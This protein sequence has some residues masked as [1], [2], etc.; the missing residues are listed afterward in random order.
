M[1]QYLSKV[2]LKAT[3]ARLQANKVFGPESKGGRDQDGPYKVRMFLSNSI[4]GEG[5]RCEENKSVAWYEDELA[6]MDNYV[7]FSTPLQEDG[8]K[9]YAILREKMKIINYEV[10]ENLLETIT[11]NL[12]IKPYFDLEMYVNEEDYD[13]PHQ[14]RAPLILF[15]KFIQTK[16]ATKYGIQLKSP[17][18]F[19]AT[20]A[21]RYD[22]KKQAFKLSFHLLIQNKIYFKTI[23]D[24]DRF[25]KH[26]IGDPFMNY[27]AGRIVSEE[28]AAFFEATTTNETCFVDPQVYHKGFQHLK[29]TF[30]SK[31]GKPNS[32]HYPEPDFP[33]VENGWDRLCGLYFG[34]GDRVCL[35]VS[36]LEIL[37]TSQRRSKSTGGVRPK[38]AGGDGETEPQNEPTV[39]PPD[40][41]VFIGK[42][43]QETK[44]IP[45]KDL[46][47]LSRYSRAKMYL[48][49]IPNGPK[50]SVNSIWLYIGW[51]CKRAGLSF[52]DWDEW[53]ALYIS[54]KGVPHTRN[55]SRSVKQWN[56]APGP[57][58]PLLLDDEGFPFPGYDIRH[59]RKVA[60]INCAARAS[61][62][63]ARLQAQHL[64]VRG[65]VKNI[66]YTPELM[67]GDYFSQ[68]L[69]GMEVRNETSDYLSSGADE[70]NLYVTQKHLI[71]DA[72]MGKGKTQA[73]KKMMKFEDENGDLLYKSVLFFSTR[74]S[75]AN[76]I[77]G[78]DF[79]DC[80][81]ENYKDIKPITVK[82]KETGGD[83]QKKEFDAERLVVS[84]E[85]ILCVVRKEYDLVILD[86]C[87]SIFKIFSSSTLTN[88]NSAYVKLRGFI[89]KSKRTIYADAF[90]F[91]R[92]LDFVRS[93]K[94]PENTILIRNQ[95][96]PRD[97]PPRTTHSVTSAAL[98]DAFHTQTLA[99]K[100]NFMC[101]GTKTFTD[102]I[103]TTFKNNSRLHPHPVLTQMF[104]PFF[105]AAD[106]PQGRLKC[107]THLLYYNKHMGDLEDKQTLHYIKE[108]WAEATAVMTTP[109]ITVGCSFA[110]ENVFH[111]TFVYFYPSCC[112][113]DLIQSHMRVRK[114][115]DNDVYYAIPDKIENLIHMRAPEVFDNLEHFLFF[116]GDQANRQHS[117][118]LKLEGEVEALLKEQGAGS[119]K[120]EALA[121][122][123]AIQRFKSVA[124]NSACPYE[125]KRILWFNTLEDALSVK[126]FP[127][128]VDIFLHD[129]LGYKNDGV[130]PVDPTADA[131]ADT[132]P[133]GLDF[134]RYS[135][136]NLRDISS[137][138]KDNL[139][140]KHYANEDS[141]LDKLL[142]KKYYFKHLFYLGNERLQNRLPNNVIIH[143]F[144][145]YIDV[146]GYEFIRNAKLEHKS[147]LTVVEKAFGENEEDDAVSLSALRPFAPIFLKTIQEL[148]VILGLP[149]S[150]QLFPKKT[151]IARADVE[152][153]LKTYFGTKNEEGEM[154]VNTLFKL[155]D[156][157]KKTR[158]KDNAFGDT[159]P[160]Q[161]WKNCLSVL[162][163][164]YAKWT[165]AG[166]RA[167]QIKPFVSDKSSGDKNKK[168][169]AFILYTPNADLTVE[170]LNEKG[171]LLLDE[172][173]K[174]L[175]FEIYLR[176][177][178]GSPYYEGKLNYELLKAITKFEEEYY[179]DQDQGYF[180]PDC[181][182]CNLPVVSF[183]GSAETCHCKIWASHYDSGEEEEFDFED[184]QP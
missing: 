92:T 164:L 77:T 50:V 15:M 86:E 157:T 129:K 47:D 140:R 109:K 17:D 122:K 171:E 112:V 85:S 44:K 131:G 124:M 22:D 36:T 106:R 64:T 52:E 117:E 24:H 12:P 184:E 150:F 149:N 28:D 54:D 38:A 141:N 72:R 181:V 71:Y 7:L 151:R 16:V 23:T 25:Y 30:Q 26:F 175:T 18:D 178:H 74:I 2:N 87:E 113:R 114:L 120:D 14:K 130:K 166:D 8:Y 136:F 115:I 172:K 39:P 153:K 42:T 45:D 148:N 98:S 110:E 70:K 118:A 146:A 81:L 159:T 21:H 40:Y 75:F 176:Y 49:L 97:R 84:L 99:G 105:Y 46:M 177:R 165:G 27:N 100:K 182:K 34:V 82:N 73:I 5:T 51:A 127:K 31:P 35:D 66:F 68:N 13:S 163:A 93:F 94:E 116:L 33:V 145:L 69:N 65:K 161:G 179:P 180:V 67:L 126:F 107:N 89:E 10:D 62:E 169:A 79:A 53:S 142:V 132:P 160:G 162:N 4:L 58:S 170:G 6:Y 57:N 167:N 61:A 91:N 119:E 137:E 108:T 143:F 88:P 144:N 78:Q 90:I 9:S 63:R 128:M 123:Q 168:N 155:I 76:F 138:E 59:L 111:S 156:P 43:L 183:S 135:Y 103:E 102:G 48:Y 11:P 37:K 96:P 152:E 104:Q 55:D 20:S 95:L 133:S 29:M 83:K 101:S 139:V 173:G 125:L 174:V 80:R 147:Y 56:R 134:D 154:W 1:S 19:F 3:F 32:R 60:K 158:Y 41:Y 121:Y